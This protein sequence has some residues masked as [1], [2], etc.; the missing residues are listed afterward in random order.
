MRIKAAW[1]ALTAPA[2]AVEAMSESYDLYELDVLDGKYN[3]AVGR[4][5][6]RAVRA[7]ESQ[8]VQVQGMENDL[9]KVRNALLYMA[10]HSEAIAK[11]MEE[12]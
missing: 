3:S 11:I 6:D 12:S 8:R 9:G 1:R 5:L 4:R 10:Q 2:G 7:V